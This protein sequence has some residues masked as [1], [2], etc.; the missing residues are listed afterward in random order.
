[1][2]NLTKEQML[3]EGF[4]PSQIVQQLIK[5]LDAAK[6]KYTPKSSKVVGFKGTTEEALQTI[7]AKK[8]NLSD[9]ECIEELHKMNVEL[10]EHERCE[11]SFKLLKMFEDG[12]L[13]RVKDSVLKYSLA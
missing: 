11:V 5:Q 13:T 10:T 1:M 4:T 8:S 9:V 6:E 2:L 7:L 12:I 3:A